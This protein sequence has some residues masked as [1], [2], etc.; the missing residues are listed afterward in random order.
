MVGLSHVLPYGPGESSLYKPQLAQLEAVQLS[1]DEPVPA[2]GEETP[3]LSLEKDANREN[4]RLAVL[5][6]LG[7]CVSLAA[8][9]KGFLTSNL[10]LHSGQRY[11]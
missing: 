10:C 9:S 11:S 2:M 4:S 5:P 7:Q 6:H 3:E 8:L 1:H